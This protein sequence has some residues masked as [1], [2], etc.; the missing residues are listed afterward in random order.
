[1]SAG[2]SGYMMPQGK[3]ASIFVNYTFYAFKHKLSVSL[4]PAKIETLIINK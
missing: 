4:N 1:M 3:S 2:P